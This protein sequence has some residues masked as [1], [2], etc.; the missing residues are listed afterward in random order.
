MRQGRDSVRGQQ[1]A[2]ADLVSWDEDK[3]EPVVPVPVAGRVPVPVRR[4][5]VPGVEEPGAAPKHPVRA[6]GQNPKSFNEV[7]PDWKK[8]L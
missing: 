2:S 6:L 3:P 4:L 8:L 7:M 5:T 1:S